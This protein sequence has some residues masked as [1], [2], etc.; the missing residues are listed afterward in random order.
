[1]A[2]FKRRDMKDMPAEFFLPPP[3]KQGLWRETATL[4]I[5]CFAFIIVLGIVVALAQGITVTP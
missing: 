3:T 5:G 1:M 4:A 2:D